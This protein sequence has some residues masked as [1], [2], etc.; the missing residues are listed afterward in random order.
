M[1]LG[2]VL[3]EQCKP[4]TPSRYYKRALQISQEIC[5]GQHPLLASTLEH[6][7][8]LLDA[9]GPSKPRHGSISSG[10]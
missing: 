8:A 9:Q 7:A 3:S 10:P 2:R 5:G 6:M 1:N 4:D